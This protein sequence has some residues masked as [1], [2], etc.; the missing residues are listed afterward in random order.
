MRRGEVGLDLGPILGGL[1]EEVD[2]HLVSAD[3]RPLMP[4]VGEIERHRI[5]LGLAEGER[6]AGAVV[7]ATDEN[8]VGPRQGR[9]SDQRINAVEIT[10]AG[11]AAPIVEGLGA[12]GPRANKCR[13][14]GWAPLVSPPL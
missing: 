8:V 5:V 3:L 7:I 6:N 14:G 4:E 10:A 12:S 1:G 9:A 11:G 2:M 13:V